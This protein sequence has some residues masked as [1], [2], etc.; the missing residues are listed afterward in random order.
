MFFYQDYGAVIKTLCGRLCFD[1]R[2]RTPAPA[3][4]PVLFFAAALLACSLVG[5]PASAAAQT[6]ARIQTSAAARTEAQAQTSAAAQTEAQAEAQAEAQEESLVTLCSMTLPYSS[7]AGSSGSNV[8][9]RLA[10]RAINGYVLGPGES[11]SYNE[12][13]GPRDEKSRFV[14]GTAYSSGKITQ[15]IG[16]GICKISTMLYY[17]CLKSGMRVTERFPHSLVVDYVPGGLDAAVAWG[18]KDFCFENTLCVPLTIRASNNPYRRTFTVD[19]CV[20]ADYTGG[21]S[22]LRYQPESRQLGEFG[23]WNYLEVYDSGGVR[24]GVVD[25]G[26]NWYLGPGQS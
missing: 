17:L 15:N 6:E 21:R 3:R 13:L 18:S 19:F 1:L 4:R 10:C 9:A 5:T 2:R 14:G 22:A 20:P 26:Q 12:A 8:N 24:I 16:G 7:N 11:F 23:Y 25:L